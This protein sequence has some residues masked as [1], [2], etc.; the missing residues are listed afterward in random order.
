M[1]TGDFVP[2]LPKDKPFGKLN[3]AAPQGDYSLKATQIPRELQMHNQQK[4]RNKRQMYGVDF[5]PI[6]RVGQVQVL[7]S[8]RPEDRLVAGKPLHVGL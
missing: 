1:A 5:V 6:V 3:K 7:K 8:V 2:D 4:M